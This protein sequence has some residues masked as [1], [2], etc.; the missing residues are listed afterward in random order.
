MNDD[1]RHSWTKLS[2]DARNAKP[3][4]IDIHRAVM[5]EIRRGVSVDAPKAQPSLLEAVD[6]LIT[7][8]WMR[9]AFALLT[10]LACGIGYS[11]YRGAEIVDIVNALIF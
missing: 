11:G 5:A 8:R 7:R 2:A 4:T 1:S 6:A 9:P 10:V 3:P